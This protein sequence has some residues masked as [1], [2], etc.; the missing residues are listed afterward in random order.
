MLSSTA[1]IVEEDNAS[2][3]ERIEITRSRIKRTDMEGAAP[4]TTITADG[5]VKM[6]V[7]NVGDMLQSLTS[8]AGVG[9]NTAVNNGGD[10]TIQ[11]LL[12]GLGSKTNAR[13][14]EWSLYG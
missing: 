11:F 8:S 9:L 3:V 10:G 4:V 12:R 14:S 6:G 7:T 13:F 5:I 2:K 1:A